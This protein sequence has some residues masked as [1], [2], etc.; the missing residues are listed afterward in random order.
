MGD[1]ESERCK[2]GSHGEDERGWWDGDLRGGGKLG[3]S[4]KT[5]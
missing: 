5:G 2:A 4:N 3:V 1:K